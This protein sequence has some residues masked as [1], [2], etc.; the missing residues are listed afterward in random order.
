VPTKAA[1]KKALTQQRQAAATAADIAIKETQARAKDKARAATAASIAAKATKAAS[2]ATAAAAQAAADKERKRARQ[3][4]AA[5]RKHSK[6]AKAATTAHSTGDGSPAMPAPSKLPAGTDTSASSRL[7]PGRP[8]PIKG[9]GA[10]RTRETRRRSA[11]SASHNKKALLKRLELN[12]LLTN[13]VFSL[14]GDDN[15]EV[16]PPHSTEAVFAVTQAQVDASAQAEFDA[17]RARDSDLAKVDEGM[18]AY[19]GALLAEEGDGPHL[20]GAQGALDA[21]IA[22]S[23]AQA[24]LPPAP[25]DATPTMATDTVPTTAKPAS[26]WGEVFTK[27]QYPTLAE[28]V[29]QAASAG[30]EVEVV[31]ALDNLGR[32]NAREWRTLK[33]AK[34]DKLWGDIRPA[35]QAEITRVFETHK[36]VIHVP[37]SEMAKDLAQYGSVK[38]LLRD[39][40]IPIKAKTNVDGD[41]TKIKARFVVADRVIDGRMD[42]VYAPAVQQDTVR[43]TKN[44]ELQIRGVS[45]VKDVEGAYLHGKPHDPASPRGRVLYARVPDGLEEFGYP[46]VLNGVRHVLKIQ[47]NVP[48][49]QDAGVIWGKAYTDFLVKDCGLKQSA[50]DRRL[51][52]RHGPGTELLLVCVYVDDNLIVAN[53]SKV[54]EKFEIA[55]S[56]RYPDSLAGGLAADV[57]SDFTGVKY[58]RFEGRME[59]SCGK[60]L[61]NLRKMLDDLPPAWKLVNDTPTDTPMDEHALQAMRDSQPG[62]SQAEELF[63]SE[64]VQMAQK[65]AGLAGWIAGSCRPD[66]YFSY[67]AV[68]Q[69]LAGGMTPTV[70]RAV[71][72]WATYLADTPDLKLTYHTPPATADW[73]MFADSSLFNNGNGS[74]FGGYVARFPGSGLFAWKSFVPRKL[75]LSSGGAETTM[76]AYAVHYAIGLRMLARE[77]GRGPSGAT[78]VYTDNLATLQGTAME[79]VPVSQRYLAARRAVV[80]Q[81]QEAGLVDIRFVG[82]ADN[83]ADMFTKPL[84]TDKFIRLRAKALGIDSSPVRTN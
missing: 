5:M 3:K 33:A 1:A 82:T 52:Y 18:S 8:S 6:N 14:Y 28:A 11:V 2:M 23:L 67:V 83:L 47:G 72:R 56:Q 45:A 51:F 78:V 57:S 68:S 60:L 73:E 63:G 54:L 79:N 42:D 16:V 58:E 10:R 40:L 27:L 34:K 9:G 48:G 55:F 80:R 64:R 49:R 69:H 50:V 77:I 39:A 66:A 21:L 53:D 75:T 20:V 36:S 62:G 41:L 31:F 81:A 65:I 38:V 61:K 37:E 4:R 71:L 43:F 32:G 25:T 74:S 44:I 7:V 13:F 30:N 22:D 19:F 12:S 29:T 26:Y 35:V 15:R 17:S 84:P 24:R 70:W 76:A 59:L 46:R